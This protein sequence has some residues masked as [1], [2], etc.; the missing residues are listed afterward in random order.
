MRATVSD[1]IYLSAMRPLELASYLRTSGWIQQRWEP[2]RFAVWTK[3]SETGE[4]F[5]IL[6]PLSRVAD[7]PARIAELLGTLELAERRSQLEIVADLNTTNADIVRVISQNAEV[8]DGS[9]P[10]ED[11]VSLVGDS[12]DMMLSAACGA[13]EHRAYYPRRKFAQAVE[14]LRGVRMGQTERGSYVVTII[15]RVPPSLSTDRGEFQEP[16]ERQ[17]TRT[18]ASSL[19]QVQ[20]AAEQAV[21]TGSLDAF[22][23]AIDYGV[24]ANLCE[25]IV[26]MAGGADTNR[27]V[28]VHLSWSRS[29]PMS[30]PLPGRIVLPVDAIPV[31]EEAGRILRGTSPLE[32]YEVEGWVEALDRPTGQDLGTVTILGFVDE[33]PHRIRLQLKDSEYHLAIRAHD[34]RV[35]VSCVGDLVKEGRSFTL[36]NP[37]YFRLIQER[38]A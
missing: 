37:H 14:Y 9:I 8:A 10:I 27:N 24:S 35:P 16:Y 5:E 30:D 33:R 7:F 19:F 3:K 28:A 17:V 11:A 38:D 15:S 31:I 22:G 6:L 36:Q 25:A 32:E 18:L 29:R 20:R 21:A 13:I 34:G 23:N 4:E 1:S 12:R 2:D 26:G